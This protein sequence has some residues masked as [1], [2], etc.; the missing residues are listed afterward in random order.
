MAVYDYSGLTIGE[1]LPIRK[2]ALA[3][4]TEGNSRTAI[5]VGGKN[6]QKEWLDANEQLKEANRCLYR[7]DPVT[8]AYCKSSGK[9]TRTVPSYS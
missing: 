6:T 7:L 1:L 2:Q 5:G 8:Y 9:V 4:I 3:R